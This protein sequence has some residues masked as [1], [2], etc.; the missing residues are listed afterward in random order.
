M[1]K[2]LTLEHRANIGK[3]NKG[4]KRSPE[5]CERMR[6]LNLNRTFSEETRKNM[7]E[8]QKGHKQTKETIEKRLATRR[9]RGTLGMSGKHHTQKAKNLISQSKTNKPSSNKGKKRTPE[10]IN[11]MRLIRQGKKLSEQHK[12]SISEGLNS[13]Y[14]NNASPN[15]GKKHS[16]EYKKIMSNALVGRIFSEAHIRKLKDS[17]KDPERIKKMLEHNPQFCD[18]QPELFMKEILAS[19]NI[20]YE[21]NKRMNIPHSYLCD[22]Y[23]PEY[24]FI[25]ECDGIL[26]HAHPSR[27]KAE[28]IVPLIKMT[29]KE[30]WE[31]DA[32]RT[33]E[34]QEAGYKVLRFW[35][36]EFD[37]EIVKSKL[38]QVD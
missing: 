33:K 8:A 24:N 23:L 34:L 36:N 38:T 27:F 37:E 4:K 26:F 30:K 13:F 16:E 15:K 31:E 21:H 32:I 20:K 9:E 11:I 6:V 19:L 35:E 28:D 22:F 17:W 1:P 5:F 29:A 2:T 3:A 14:K 18:T 25:I 10:Q 12:K 7:S